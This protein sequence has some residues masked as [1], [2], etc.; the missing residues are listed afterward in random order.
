[1]GF[2]K[3]KH[4]I[5]QSLCFQKATFQQRN[6]A[7]I[8][9]APTGV[10]TVSKSNRQSLLTALAAG[11]QCEWVSLHS[12]FPRLAPLT[13][14]VG[15]TVHSKDSAFRTGLHLNKDIQC[16]DLSDV[17]TY[18]YKCLCNSNFYPFMLT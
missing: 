2:Q 17:M 6:A 13:L 11:P 10:P 18:I 9:W 1:M 14:P 3:T 15:V 4:S 5:E 12:S 8:P 7:L 16:S